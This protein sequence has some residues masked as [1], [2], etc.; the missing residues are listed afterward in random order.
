MIQHPDYNSPAALKE[1]M[2]QSNMAMQKKFGQ[3]F[4]VNEDA[5]KRLIDSLEVEKDMT[6]WEVGPGLG[7]M[8]DELLRRG[9]NLTVFEIDHGF[10][11]LLPE[12]FEEYKNSGHFNLVEGD[13]L[14]TWPKYAEG[15]TAPSR[16]FGNLPY[17]VA[18]TIIA[19]TINKGFRFDRAVFTIQ[20]EVGLRMTAKPGSDDYS[21]FSVLCQWAYDVKPVMDLAGGNFWPKPNVASRAVLMTKKE[22]FP[23]CNNPDLFMKMIRQIFAL[24]RKTIRNNLT[25]FVQPEQCDKALEI[26]GIAPNE[27]AENLSV[28]KLLELSD[29]INSV[30]IK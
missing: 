19:D 10:A 25:K 26:A 24:R 8:T 6:V 16:F 30:I 4:L 28:E 5:R 2:E 3:N 27:R 12:F 20:K 21:S 14:K 17:N 29:A 7:S 23:C 15:K 22:D 18:A 11:R 1:F 13:V 9:V